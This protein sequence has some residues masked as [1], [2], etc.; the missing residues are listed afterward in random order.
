MDLKLNLIEGVAFDMDGLIFDTEELARKAFFVAVDAFKIEVE[1]DYYKRFVGN[2]QP[3]CDQ[4][5]YDRFGKDFD[6][7]GFRR[8]WWQ[9]VGELFAADG[10]EF[11][12][13]FHE[14]FELI[15]QQKLP[16]ALV[17]TSSHS[18]VLRNFRHWDYPERFSTLVTWDRGLP[19]K[20]APDK[21]L[22]AA[23]DLSVNI[24]NMIVLEDS[25]T[26]MQAAI[27]AKSKA[28]MIPDLVEPVAEVEAAAFGIFNDLIEVRHWL[29][30]AL[31]DS[32]VRKQ[33]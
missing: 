30:S 16:I 20:P 22:A 17:T 28:V 19:S 25:N 9:H 7:D 1:A 13:G 2:S 6:T 27:N 18:T 11:K 29:E 15:E 26:G 12:P 4:L 31:G 10:V 33:L 8:H 23:N 21:Y 24:N 14:L 3:V 32:Y 5:M